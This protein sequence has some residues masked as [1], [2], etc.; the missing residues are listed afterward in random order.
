MINGKRILAVIPARGGSKGIKDKNII[1]LEGKPLIAYTIEAAGES[2]YI[3]Y[4]YVSTDS[5]RIRDVSV[6][7]GAKVPFMRSEEL[8][9]DT[10]KTIDAIVYTLEKME[11]MGEK[12]DVMILLQPT[13]PLRTVGDIDGA[14]EKFE[15]CG[16]GSLV[17]VS[18]V[19]DPPVLMR[20]IRDDRH[21]EKLIDTSSTVRRQDMEKYYRVNGSIYIN[22]VSEINIATSFNDNEVPYI[23]PKEN[24]VDI[25]EYAD[26]ELAG[27][28][29]RR[30]KSQVSG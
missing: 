26:L 23:V 10:S 27:Y 12:F 11:E 3:D 17:S 1:E 19:N 28:Y 5:E 9:S 24:A 30:G 14:I 16:C 4:V 29:I 6:R 7:Y 15:R 8:A 22:R 18:E 21:M 25:D 20:T 2:R 13:S